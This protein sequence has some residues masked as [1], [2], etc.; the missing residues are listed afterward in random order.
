MWIFSSIVG[1][2][3]MY[4]VTLYYIPEYKFSRFESASYNS[5]HRLGWAIF[6]GWLTLGSVTSDG[7]VVKKFLSAQIF[8]PI[9]RL[10]YCAYLTNGFIELYLAATIRTPKYMSV[11]NL[12]S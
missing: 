5:L 3:S 11:F 1:I 4:G 7:G 12:V 8:V 6:T 2:I 10:T 9:S